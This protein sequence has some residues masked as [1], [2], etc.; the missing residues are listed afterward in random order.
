MAIEMSFLRGDL[1]LQ[2]RFHRGK[3]DAQLPT[4]LLLQGSPGNP[5][6]VL[7]LGERFA[8]HGYNTLTFNYC[9]THNSEGLSS[10]ADA[11]LDIAAAYRFLEECALPGVDSDRVILGGWSYG[12]GMAL[13]YA[14]GHPEFPL[15]SRSQE[16]IT[17]N[18]CVSTHVI[19]PSDAWSMASLLT[20][21]I[22][23]VHGGL[24]QEPHQGKRSNRVLP[25]TTTTSRGQHQISPRGT[26]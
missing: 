21:N 1:R 15:Y 9:G 5:V 18:S 8:K 23:P 10:F 2:A 3:G 26:C 19:R 6:D 14:A 16:P 7:G 13:T 4:V 12:G 11:Q 25:L 24:R 20:W 17:A 22:P